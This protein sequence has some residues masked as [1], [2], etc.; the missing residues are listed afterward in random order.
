[1]DHIFG[2]DIEPFVASE[3]K[4]EEAKRA[5]VKARRIVGDDC[6]SILHNRNVL[7]RENCPDIGLVLLL[8]G[9]MGRK[10]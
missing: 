7:L 3:P 4:A 5:K 6:E 2:C 1:V 10:I 8:T 9:E